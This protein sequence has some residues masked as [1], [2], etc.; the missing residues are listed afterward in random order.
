MA[1]NNT[2]N[3]VTTEIVCIR[4]LLFSHVTFSSEVSVV[5]NI[6]S[7]HANTN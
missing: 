7:L 2:K 4:Q 5:F 1:V 6:S 3:I